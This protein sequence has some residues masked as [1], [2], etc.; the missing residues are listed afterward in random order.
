MQVSVI[1]NPKSGM[2]GQ[3][4]NIE[5]R[6]RKV[7]ENQ[8]G[9][10]FQF[11]KTEYPGHAS[12]L[13]KESASRGDTTCFAAGGDGT[14]NEVARGLIGSKTSLGIIP[15]GSGNGLARHLKI[16]LNLEEAIIRQL[17]GNSKPM[18]HGEI[19]SKK[20]FLAAGIGFEGVV[21]NRFSKKQLRGFISYLISASQEFFKW[22]NVAYRATIEKEKVG[23]TAFSI[24]FANGSQYGNNAIISPG[25]EIDDG[26]LQFVRVLPFSLLAA[27]KLFFQLMGGSIYKSVYHLES[28]FTNLEL[29]IEGKTQIEGHVDGEAVVFSLPL[30]VQVKPGSL[31]VRMPAN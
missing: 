19:N 4:N 1:L 6:I 22:K 24:V 18:D 15:L 28:A 16:P 20:F 26:I 13:A 9:L 21:T 11:L 25:S 30:S 10:T 23:G 14:M 8:D 29:S 31:F 27:P 3:N 2:Q 5:L 7:L 17:K 12:E